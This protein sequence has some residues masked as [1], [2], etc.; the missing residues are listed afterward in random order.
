M[1]LPKSNACNN[2]ELTKRAN[3]LCPV[4]RRLHLMSASQRLKY[5]YKWDNVKKKMVEVGK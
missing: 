3:I 1:I 2:V 4:K 5:G